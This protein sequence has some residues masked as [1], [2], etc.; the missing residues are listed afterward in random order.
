M[1]EKKTSI[2]TISLDQENNL[3]VKCKHLIVPARL[4]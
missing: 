1:V 2:K 3:A 4:H